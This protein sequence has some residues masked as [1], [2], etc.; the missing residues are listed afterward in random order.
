MEQYAR[1]ND[2]RVLRIS[3]DALRLLQNYRWPGNVRELENVVRRA[4]LLCRGEMIRPDD[5]N[6]L[7]SVIDKGGKP[8]PDY[9]DIPGTTMA[10][11][12]RFAILKTLQHT[13][14]STSQ[15]GEI[16]HISPRKIQYKLREYQSGLPARP[17]GKRAK[18]LANQQTT[19]R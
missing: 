8:A 15:A 3:E 7:V 10:E 4:A 19:A 13:G 5:I 14:G 12:Q 17:H 1:E 18:R 16:L 6:G 9:P 2:T 11:I